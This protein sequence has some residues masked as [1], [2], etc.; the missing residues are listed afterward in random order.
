MTYQEPGREPLNRDPLIR[1]EPANSNR[2]AADETSF[3]GWVIG[4]AAFFIVAL[5][6]LFMLPHRTN[7]TASNNT[8]STVSSSARVPAS[9]TGSGATSPA[10]AP[11]PGPANP[12]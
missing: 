2:Q 8:G 4:A 11:G 7:N 1:P 10:P 3:P 6:V 5:A 9:T 12:R